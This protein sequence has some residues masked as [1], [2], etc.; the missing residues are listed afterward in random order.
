MQRPWGNHEPD[1]LSMLNLT[2]GREGKTWEWNVQVR[3]SGAPC[4]VGGTK[5]V[6][7]R[8]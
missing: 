3:S 6:D 1:L 2:Q 8:S 4:G 7:I 5:A